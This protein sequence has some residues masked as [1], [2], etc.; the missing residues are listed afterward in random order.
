MWAGVLSVDGMYL[1]G[2]VGML[3]TMAGAMAIR[4]HEY[5]D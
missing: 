1:W 2:H 4:P 5:I 3:F